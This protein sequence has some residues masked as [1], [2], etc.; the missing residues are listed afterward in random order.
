MP[1]RFPDRREAGRRL[2]AALPALGDD[3]VVVLGLPRGG[4]PVAYEVALALGA[5]LDVVVVRKVGVPGSPELAMGAVGEG[6][7]LL[8]NEPVLAHA[9]VRDDDFARIV[10]EERKEVE[11][12]AARLR[13]GRP[14]APLDGCTAVVVDDGLATGST[15]RVALTVLRA[16]GV[17][18]ALLAVPVASADAVR[19]LRRD[20]V[21]VVAAVQPEP[22]GAVGRWYD[23]FRATPEDEVAALLDRAR[24]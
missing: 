3:R 6:G 5:P 17:A 12:R 20:G 14:A 9:R 7:D 13:D 11:R 1:G 21:E 16:A 24:G 8:R 18:R 23:D 2:A 4:V 15:A 19:D 10:D 22:F